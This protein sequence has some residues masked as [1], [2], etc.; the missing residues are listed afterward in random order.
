HHY[1]VDEHLIRAVGNVASIERGEHKEDNP[2]STDV[3]KRVQSRAVLYCAI[4][5]HDIAKG[6]PGDHSDVGAEIA[7][8]LC[9]RLGLSSA[10]TEAVAWLVKNHLVMSD[11]AQRRDISDPK[12]VK[13]FV[14]QVQAP[15]ML[16][17]LLVLTVA[18][19]RAVG[20]GVW[21]GWKG[22]LLRELYH[23]AEQLMAG[24]DQAPARSARVES[25]KLALN[26]RLSDVPEPERAVLLA[27]HYD[28]YWVAFDSEEQERHA[29]LML[30]ADRAG[31]LLTVGIEANSFR[32]VTEIALYTPD[33]PGLFSQ[34][35]GAIAMSGGS[36]VDA[37]VTTTSHGFA[38]DIFSVQDM[39]GQA[40][41]DPDRL[42]R[43][44]QTIEKTV[45]G[46]IWPRRALTG[47]RP[48]RARTS[49]F[50][51]TP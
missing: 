22:Q 42:M 33:H 1:T 43:L 40:F 15:E 11:T 32:D 26:E 39:D 30:K 10:D 4:L 27:R 50:T 25:A 3:V 7:H 47:K 28:S 14:A 38:L 21:N 24:G 49:A 37:K 41:D 16:R 48:L 36:I 19:I 51:I 29:R 9:P 5:L 2:L 20:P 46:E 18:D 35:A 13:D 23:A 45:R 12:T 31:D 6:L 17:L 44:K 34:F 8:R